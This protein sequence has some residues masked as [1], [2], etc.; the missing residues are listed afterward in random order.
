MKYFYKNIRLLEYRD[1]GIEGA[2]HSRRWAEGRERQ[3]HTGPFARRD[4]RAA[5]PQG[6]GDRPRP[7]DHRDQLA[8]PA[9][10]REPRRHVLYTRPAHVGLD[11]IGQS[12]DLGV[13][14][15]ASDRSAQQ[16]TATG[17]LLGT[18]AAGSIRGLVRTVIRASPSAAMA[19][20]RHYVHR[21]V[22]LVWIGPAPFKGAYVC[23]ANDSPPTI[24]LKT[25]VRTP[26]REI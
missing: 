4:R 13:R 8:R 7:A 2:N 18:P 14:L 20:R 15:R 19:R 11:L 16:A 5:R 24:E 6:A 21:L 26:R 1:I 9:E 22:A 17:R 25:F 10:G 3:N 12:S 23:H